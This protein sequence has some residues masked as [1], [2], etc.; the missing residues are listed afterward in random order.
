MEL[1]LPS[2]FSELEGTALPKIIN[3]ISKTKYLNHV[4]IGLDRAN[5]VKSHLI[6]KGVD[7]ERLSTVGYGEDKPKESNNTR[8]GR[9]ANRRVEFK[10]VE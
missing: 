1:I 2:L 8:N 10:V 7:S 5:K 3:E 9:I 6:D 4:I